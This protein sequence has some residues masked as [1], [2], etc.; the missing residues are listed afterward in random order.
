MLT[1][2]LA[3]IL[4][5]A[6]LTACLGSSDNPRSPKNNSD[7][8]SGGVQ[9]PTADTD[10]D[11][12]INKN[13]N[14][15]N[16]SNPDQKDLDNDKIGDACDPDRDGDGVNN[17]DDPFPDDGSKS[18][19]ADKD[20]ISD[21]NDNCPT[22][23][24]TNQADLDGDNVGDACDTDKDGDG[25]NNDDDAFPD[26]KTETHDNDSDGTGDNADTD[27]DNDGFSDV[28]EIAAG[29]DPKNPNS[30]PCVV[31]T[32]A[33]NTNVCASK[34]SQ[35]GSIKLDWLITADSN[36]HHY[37]LQYTLDGSTWTDSQDNLTSPATLTLPFSLI[38]YTQ[39][40]LRLRTLNANNN[41]IAG[42]HSSEFALS[43]LIRSQALI[44]RFKTASPKA[45]EQ[46]GSSLAS[47][48]DGS[49][50][51]S[52]A[53]NT[54]VS[55]KT[56]AGAVLINDMTTTNGLTSATPTLV[57]SPA[58]TKDE[59]FGHRIALSSDGTVLAVMASG[60]KPRIYLFKY[61]ASAWSHQATIAH[62]TDTTA[63]NGK[64][65]LLLDTGDALSGTA[66]HMALDTDGD[67]LAISATRSDNNV[68]YLFE[69]SGGAWQRKT[70]QT[71]GVNTRNLTFAQLS[72]PIAMANS[73]NWVAVGLPE[74]CIPTAASPLTDC[75]NNTAIQGSGSVKVFALSGGSWSL[76]ATLKA[77]SADIEANAW[78]GQALATNGSNV[79]IV[80]APSKDNTTSKVDAGAV[81]EYTYSG[82]TWT[83]Q[84]TIKGDQPKESLGG[85]ISLS[86]DAKQLALSSTRRSTTD[87]G[88]VQTLS[89]DNNQPTQITV[90]TYQRSS[91]SSGW[92]AFANLLPPYPN[93]ND[94]KKG[95]F[96]THLCFSG[97]NSADKPRKLLIS[98]PLDDTASQISGET[99]DSGAV[100]WY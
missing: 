6:T 65:H 86:P 99:T 94:D 80:G 56:K 27:D 33:S 17:G 41:E 69:L 91:I 62:S 90:K 85:A 7:S 25:V 73:G 4:L 36:A 60:T 57:Q 48:T 45:N 61:N 52:G 15:P 10:K 47:T 11:G 63:I 18:K 74:D 40:K 1:S 3:T 67:T 66:T 20:G 77:P 38:H 95:L 30:K 82:A 58:P 24:N 76:D 39:V 51:V 92:S 64:T 96:A 59:Y 13:D 8:G 46:Y 72:S 93:T 23:A 16:V 50:W 28:D 53:P 44:G 88:V 71:L 79:L 100:F 21:Q 34:G 29:T 84:R 9:I 70:R 49:R 35:P 12:I 2:R 31:S 37:T 75:S 98:T 81:Y 55:G 83:H 5:C 14:C 97:D 43:G 42:Q 26:N 68:L 87:S 19:D 32:A 89:V 54:E 22:K 78:F